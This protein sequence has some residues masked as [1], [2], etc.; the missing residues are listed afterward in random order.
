MFCFPLHLWPLIGN[1]WQSLHSLHTPESSLSASSHS[2][3]LCSLV[4]IGLQIVSSESV[5]LG[6]AFSSTPVAYSHLLPW[7][8]TLSPRTDRHW[9]AYGQSEA[10]IKNGNNCSQFLVFFWLQIGSPKPKMNV[11]ITQWCWGQASI[12]IQRHLWSPFSFMFVILFPSILT[13][14][15][16]C[17]YTMEEDHSAHWTDANPL[18]QEFSLLLYLGLYTMSHIYHLPLKATI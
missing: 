8:M 16:Q 4:Q 14:G 3:S 1:T 7:H 18:Q 2:D 15:S 12:Q 6:N 17:D 11:I 9:D 13:I 10:N 5:G